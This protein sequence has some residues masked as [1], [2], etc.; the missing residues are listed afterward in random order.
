M[1]KKRYK[2][3]NKKIK[4]WYFKWK[5]DE[6]LEALNDISLL[7]SLQDKF[8]KLLINNNKQNDWK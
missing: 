6:L 2:D 4:E 7:N 8:R 3:I 1:Q 5:V